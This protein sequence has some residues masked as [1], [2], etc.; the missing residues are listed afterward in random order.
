[1][2]VLPAAARDQLHEICQQLVHRHTVL[3]QWGFGQRLSLGKGVNALF[4]GPSGTGKTMAADIIANAV[5]EALAAQHTD[6]LTMGGKVNTASSGGVDINALA[7]AVRDALAVELARI[8]AN[9]SSRA[10]AADVFA[11]R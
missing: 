5:W 1:M 11:A 7:D 8:D 2:I 6:S 4:A 3:G 9:V 10:T